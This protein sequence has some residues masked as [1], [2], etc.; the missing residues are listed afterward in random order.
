MAARARLAGRDVPDRTKGD[1]RAVIAFYLLSLGEGRR[2]VRDGGFADE[3][4]WLCGTMRRASRQRC[5]Q[6]YCVRTGPEAGVGTTV[7]ELPFAVAA[8][9]ADNSGDS[10]SGV[11]D[12][13]GVLSD[14][15][16]SSLGLTSDGGVS[17][18]SIGFGGS[19]GTVG[20]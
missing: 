10:V 19:G 14:E 20:R 6:R 5:V 18:C 1:D 12:V 13:S 8:P 17:C 15:A 3:W 11:P 16:V 7:A 9:P 4:A 2:V